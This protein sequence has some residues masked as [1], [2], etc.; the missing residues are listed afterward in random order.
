MDVSASANTYVDTASIPNMGQRNTHIA[1]LSFNINIFAHTRSA[2]GG[3]LSV[4]RKFDIHFASQ[5]FT[6]R[7]DAD[8]ICINLRNGICWLCIA[9]ERDEQAKILC[10]CHF[11]KF[12][13]KQFVNYSGRYRESKVLKCVKRRLRRRRYVCFHCQVASNSGVY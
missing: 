2:L 7:L 11:V 8:R 13:E 6:R 1:H 5:F 10:T 12:D 9:I 3:S 4:V